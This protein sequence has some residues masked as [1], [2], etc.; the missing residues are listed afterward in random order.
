ML[1]R[2]NLA[3]NMIYTMERTMRDL[4]EKVPADLKKQAE[5]A[6]Q[7]LKGV[8][9]GEDVEAIRS[10]TEALGQILQKIGAAAYQ[11]G[12]PTAGPAGGAPGGP[13]GPGPDGVVDGEFRNL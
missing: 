11:Q 10:K 2:S 1:F 5:D 8:V 4:G 7:A 6:A 13:G 9:N 3:D 12:G